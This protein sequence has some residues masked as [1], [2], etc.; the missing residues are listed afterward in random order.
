[1]FSLISAEMPEQYRT[2]NAPP[3][4]GVAGR[5]KVFFILN[6]LTLF[7]HLSG[8]LF[9][10]SGSYL[11]LGGTR[12]TRIHSTIPG[13][14]LISHKDLIWSLEGFRGMQ[15]H[16]GPRCKYLSGCI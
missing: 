11:T 16:I 8:K 15:G 10:L 3:P 9:M 5:N 12:K 6:C 13:K 14:F 1:M 7:F 4:R 2:A